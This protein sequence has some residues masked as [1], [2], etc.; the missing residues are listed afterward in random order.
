MFQSSIPAM[1]S[2]GESVMTA[3]ETKRF[4]PTLE[5]IRRKD[6]NPDLLNR[7][8]QGNIDYDRLANAIIRGNKSLPL[9]SFAFDEKGFSHFLHEGNSRKQII[10]R[11]YKGGI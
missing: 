8:A 11:R 7:S 2:K 3:E 6:I 9:N 5:A 4:R 10:A 1:L